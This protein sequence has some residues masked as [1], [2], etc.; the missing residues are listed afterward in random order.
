MPIMSRP[1]DILPTDTLVAVL[2][3]GRASRFGADKL[4]QPCAGK[5]LGQWSLEAAQASGLPIVWIAG[6]H[7]PP[8]LEVIE[9]IANPRAA[10]GISTSVAL[11]AE[12]AQARGAD[13]LLVMLADMPLV[14]PGL[15]ARLI[16]TGAPAAC[17]QA[18]GRAGVPAL[19][20]A[21]S[22]PALMALTGDRGAAAVMAKVASLTLLDCAANELIDVDTPEALAEAARLLVH[23]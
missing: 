18:D 13:A 16:A 5:P 7:T 8:F 23:S 12:V 3:A 22:Y 11:A 6:D 20:P 10:E 4:A 14:T 21:G 17:R 2:G 15:L 1:A 19:I 9:V